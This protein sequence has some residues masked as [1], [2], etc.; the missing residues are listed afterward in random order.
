MRSSRYSIIDFN[1]KELTDPSLRKKVTAILIREEAAESLLQ[2]IPD[3]LF[4]ALQ[5]V[6]NLYDTHWWFAQL[7]HVKADPV[8]FWRAKLWDQIIYVATTVNYHSEPPRG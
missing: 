6:L 8:Q 5:I 4:E 2:I 1:F 3:H 7:E